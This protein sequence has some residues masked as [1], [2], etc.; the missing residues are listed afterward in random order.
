MRGNLW[1]FD[2]RNNARG[3]IPACAGE[4]LELV[5]AALG[6]WVYPRVCGG[7]RTGSERPARRQGL[8]PRVRGN[9]I[10]SRSSP[11]VIGSIPACAGEPGR[12]GEWQ[13]HVKVYPRVCGGT[14][15]SDDRPAS[16]GGLSPR[17]RGNQ[18]ARGG[19]WQCG[20]SIPACAG[21]PTTM[22]SKLSVSRVYPRVCG[23]TC[24]HAAPGQIGNGLSPRVRGNRPDDIVFDAGVRS[25]PACAG[26]PLPEVE[27]EADTRVYPRVCGGT[28]RPRPASAAYIGLS[29]RVRGN[30][31]SAPSTLLPQ[32]SIPACAGEPP[33]PGV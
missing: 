32:G 23:G 6:E 31:Q 15:W 33:L 18:C 29:P 20:W 17:V 3:S 13:I 4:P 27:G 24:H 28:W 21:E 19:R 30:R 11:S 8:S 10:A 26:E 2:A 7:T 5:R 1:Q 9:P 16:G 14:P 22:T 12:T 25:I